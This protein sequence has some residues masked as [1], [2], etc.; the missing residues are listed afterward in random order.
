MSIYI[1]W[2]VEPQENFESLIEKSVLATL[3][4]ESIEM[5]MEI[6]V[7]IVDN[8]EIQAIN[9]DQRGIDQATD[10]LSFPMIEFQLYKSADEAIAD[11]TPN[12]E[13]GLVYLGDVVLSWDKVIEQSAAYGHSREREMSFLIVHSVLHLIGYDHM[14]P[15]EEREMIEHQKGIMTALGIGR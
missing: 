4:Y 2:L 6:A 10:V 11:T 7:T 1:E 5:E 8:E 13:N 14:N 9:L 12:P 15:D 3:K